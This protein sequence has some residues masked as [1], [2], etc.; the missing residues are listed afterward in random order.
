V[1][2]AAAQAQ[3]LA[4]PGPALVDS[5]LDPPAPPAPPGPTL[6]APVEGSGGAG[7][8]VSTPHANGIRNADASP[9]AAAIP[10]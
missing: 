1:K 4:G 9:I 3:T 10:T 6:L 7:G 8:R 2:A 5:A